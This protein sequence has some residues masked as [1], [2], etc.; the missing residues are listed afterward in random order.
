MVGASPCLV[1]A[2]GR[3]P[4]PVPA[5]R[6]KGAIIQEDTDTRK[7]SPITDVEVTAANDLAS[8][9]VKSDFSGFFRLTAATQESSVARRSCSDSGIL[10]I[11]PLDM[12]VD[13]GRQALRRAHDAAAPR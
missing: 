4:L 8:A 2:A 9:G 3:L 7:Q 12:P 1:L 6:S 10:I 5:L 11:E 13:R